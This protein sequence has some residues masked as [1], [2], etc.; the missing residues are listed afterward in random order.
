MTSQPDIFD[1]NPRLNRMTSV[2]STITKR[3]GLTTLERDAKI[4]EFENFIKNADLINKGRNSYTVDEILTQD[5]IGK[6]ANFFYFIGRLNPPHN[7]HIKA[8]KQLIELANSQD[9]VPLILLGSGPGSLRT[10][11]NPITFE[12]KKAFIESVLS[13]RYEIRKM[14]NPAKNISEYIEENLQE[15]ISN[16]AKITINHIAGGKDEDTTKLAF[17]LKSAENSARRIVPEADI[18]TDVKVID[19]ETTDSGAAMSATKVRKDAYKTVLANTG[20]EGWSQQYKD[21]Y[22]SNAEQIYNEILFPLQEIPLTEREEIIRSY[23][24]TGEIRTTKKRKRGGTKRKRGT[25]RRNSR[26]KRQTKKRRMRVTRR[27]Y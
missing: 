19:A 11:D 4:S 21:F 27:K 24:E 18:I 25:K 3:R 13:G 6:E 5:E 15:P 2:G 10:M 20:F 17:A 9:S 1:I 16:I 22:G 12:A 23:I 14:T 8:L 26:N 7:G